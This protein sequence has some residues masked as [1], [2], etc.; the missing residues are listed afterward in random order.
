MKIIDRLDTKPD[1]Y[2][3]IPEGAESL[4]PTFKQMICKHIAVSAPKDSENAIWLYQVGIKIMSSDGKSVQL[5]DADFKAMA[6]C[7]RANFGQYN[8]NYQAQLLLLL[9]EWETPK[10][11]S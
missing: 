6:D 7:V 1:H 3:K 2:E 10:K 5:E 11:E 4:I 8:T 9:K